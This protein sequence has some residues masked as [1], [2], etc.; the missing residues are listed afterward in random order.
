[1]CT[2]EPVSPAARSRR[3]KVYPRVYG[4]TAS[5][6]SCTPMTGGLSPCVRGN[7]LSFF[8]RCQ[9]RGSIPVC[10]GEP[11]SARGLDRTAEVYPR[12]YGGTIQKVGGKDVFVGLSPCVRGNRPGEL[13]GVFAFRSIPVCTGEPPGRPRSRAAA[14]V[15]PRVYGG[16]RAADRLAVSAVGLSPC[17]RGN[18][19]RSRPI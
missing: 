17:V 19:R 2:G 4:G 14:K 7:L 10:T 8:D 12:V 16:T 6:A 9:R 5:R 13:A 11:R 15:Y 1:M 3:G 18:R